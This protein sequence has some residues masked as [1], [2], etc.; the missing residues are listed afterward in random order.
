MGLGLAR[1]PCQPTNPNPNQGIPLVSFINHS[2][3]PNCVYD[4]ESNGICASRDLRADEEATVNYF[5][6]QVN[7]K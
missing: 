6:Y 4:P 1:P 5:E 3:R 7:T 2:L